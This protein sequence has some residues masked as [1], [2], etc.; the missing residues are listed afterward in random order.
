M[1][2]RWFRLAKQR[3][4]GL[5]PLR[6]SA[7]TRR[8]DLQD[9]SRV[10]ACDYVRYAASGLFVAFF[11]LLPGRGPLFSI[12]YHEEDGRAVASHRVAA[13]P[14]PLAKS[15]IL[16]LARRI[17]PL[18]HT[19]THV[20]GSERSEIRR[21]FTERIFV[22]SKQQISEWILRELYNRGVAK[23]LHSEWNGIKRAKLREVSI[24]YR[25]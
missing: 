11:S 19:H 24:T 6:R 7:A 4:I 15:N 17:Q 20:H 21:N 10:E 12:D 16:I 5:R 8:D 23:L 2:K 25:L 14:P 13:P 9:A 22:L 3:L 1:V 18:T